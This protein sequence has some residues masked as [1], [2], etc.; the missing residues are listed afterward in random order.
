VEGDVKI[1]IQ[2]AAGKTI[3]TLDGTKDAGFNRVWWDLRYDKT[4]EVKLRTAPPF[5]PDV[6]L[7]PEGFRALP[8]GGRLAVLAPPGTYTVALKVKDRT[9]TQ[10]L[11]VRKDPNTAGTDADVASQTK[12]MMEIRDNV[13]AAADMINKIEAVRSQLAAMPSYLASDDAGKSVRGSAE[14]LDKKLQA[15][16]AKL[17]QTRVTGRGQDQLRWPS[18]LVEKLLYLAD[19]VALADF[20]PAKEQI[21]VHELLGGRLRDARKE[22]DETLAKDLAAFG[23]ELRQRNITGVIVPQ[24]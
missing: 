10:K 1:S 14:A 17:F 7:G 6:R 18:Q 16:E 11:E 24:Q 15:V 8:Q 22:L 13:D 19:G 23:A 2:D 3:R 20:A 5:A 9:L 21:E 12:V 4:R